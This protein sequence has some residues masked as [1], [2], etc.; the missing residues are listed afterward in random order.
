MHATSLTRILNPDSRRA[1]F[2]LQEGEYWSRCRC[3]CCYCCFC[4]SCWCS[5]SISNFR[6]TL[7]SQSQ[8]FFIVFI[9]K[10]SEFF[11][12]FLFVSTWSIFEIIFFSLSF[13]FFLFLI[14]NYF[15]RVSQRNSF[16]CCCIRCCCCCCCYTEEDKKAIF[17]WKKRWVAWQWWAWGCLMKRSLGKREYFQILVIGWRNYFL[18]L[19]RRY[20][21]GDVMKKR[22]ISN[23]YCY[24][25]WNTFS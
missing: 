15:S 13:P 21:N 1:S 2:F 8:L 20:H 7:L 19:E 3:C 14:F 23:L 25:L 24:Q 6:F 4:C 9:Q 16:S 11:S 22:L 5:L 12:A 17:V 10:E 18:V